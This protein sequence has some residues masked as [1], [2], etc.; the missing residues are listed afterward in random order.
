LRGPS[1]KDHGRL[2]R[3]AQREKSAE[4]GISRDYDAAFALG[5]IEDPSVVCN[6]YSP[7]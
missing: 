3:F 7:T 6:P 2:S 4:V 5:A 1:E